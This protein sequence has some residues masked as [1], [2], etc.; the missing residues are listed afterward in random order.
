MVL[1]VPYMEQVPQEKQMFSFR[2][3]NS[4]S[5][6]APLR[7]SPMD[8]F[9]SG[10]TKV[11]PSS[12]SKGTIEPA[13]RNMQGLFND[14]AAMSMPGTILSQAQRN[15]NPSKEWAFTMASMEPAISSLWGRM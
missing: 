3:V 5:E 14:A 11:R 12:D 10:V 7:R 13:V 6:M 2:R 15:A 4:S 1:A 9:R 8:S